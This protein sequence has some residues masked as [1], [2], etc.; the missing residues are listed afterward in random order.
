MIKRLASALS[1]WVAGRLSGACLYALPLSVAAGSAVPAAEMFDCE[2]AFPTFCRNI[3]VS[4]SGKVALTAPQVRVTI[5][6]QAAALLFT[7]DGATTSRQGTARQARDLLIVFDQEPGYFQI[8]PDGR[9]AFRLYRDHE[10]L[11]SIG[12]C[13]R[14]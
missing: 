8:E 3:H 6:R 2:P 12:D 5:D 4:C 1:A 13:R 9:Y 14:R 7:A 11:M 10:G